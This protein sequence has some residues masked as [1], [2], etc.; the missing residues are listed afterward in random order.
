[1]EKVDGFHTFIEDLS[2][3]HLHC[4]WAMQGRQ[5]DPHSRKRIKMKR[6]I[7]YQEVVR[8]SKYLVFSEE[9]AEMADQIKHEYKMFERYDS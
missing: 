2:L 8:R 4:L 9:D 1:M 5:Q 3:A 7:I 6:R